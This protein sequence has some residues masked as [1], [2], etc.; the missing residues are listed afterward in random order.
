MYLARS[1]YSS[2]KLSDLVG[3]LDTTDKVPVSTA[4]VA[5]AN[6]DFATEDV[7]VEGVVAEAVRF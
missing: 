1:C 7:E 4:A 5:A 3:Y 2:L 6:V